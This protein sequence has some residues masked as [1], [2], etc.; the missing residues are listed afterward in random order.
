MKLF[1]ENVRKKHESKEDVEIELGSYK[2][3]G[4]S[5]NLPLYINYISGV[6]K[7]GY[8]ICHKPSK[9][10]KN[11]TFSIDK[12]LTNELLEDAKKYLKEKLDEYNEK[13]LKEM[14]NLKIN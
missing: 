13:I 10:K 9:I 7:H 6:K 8:Q 11:F 4:K 5:K 2:R 1:L 3:N 12:E 14:E